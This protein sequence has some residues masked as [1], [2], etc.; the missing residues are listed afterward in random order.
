VFS[1]SDALLLRPVRLPE[2]ERLV[3]VYA[4]EPALGE[5]S[6]VVAG[7][8][9]LDWRA[10]A[11]SFQALAAY[12]RL[13][14]NL[15]GG[16]FP[17]RIS[18]VSV[19]PEFFDVLDVPAALGRT[20]RSGEPVGS[21][22]AVLASSFWQARFGADPDIIGR[23]VILNGEAHAI[24]GVMPPEFD[25]PP[26]A[27]IFVT[28]PHRVPLQPRDLTDM[29][30][31][32][33]AQY[34]SVVGRL[35]DGVSIA[36]A[37]AEMDGLAAQLALEFPDTQTDEGVSVV[38]LR[39]ALV[40]EVKPTLLL[41]L[42]AVG[43]VMLISCANVANLLTVRVSQ[44]GRELAVRLGLGASAARIRRQLL[45]ESV[46]LSLFG[47]LAGFA[48]AVGGTWGLV[49][50]APEGIP[51]L[52]EV[53]VDARVFGFST[54]LA[55]V[56]GVLFGLAPL[57]G[58][59][60]RGSGLSPWLRGS[61]ATEKYRSRLRDIVVV[62]EVALSLVLL[63]GAGLMVRTFQQLQDTDPGFDPGHT[64]VAH[65]SL[66][67][68]EYAEEGAIAA[69]YDDV[70]ARLRAIPE[71]ESAATVL[72]L[73]MHWAMRGTFT[74]AIEG[75]PQDAVDFPSAG[76]QV[77]SPDYFRTLRIPLLRG[78][79][80]D[81]SDRIET[82]TVA[83]INQALADRYWP[84]EDPVGKRLTFWGDPDDPETEW[85]TVIGV[86]ADV[87]TGGLDSSPEPEV[88]LAHSQ[89]ALNHTTFVVRTSG[90]P[91]SVASAVRN[92]VK[93]ADPALPLYGLL[94]MDEVVANAIAPR[95]YRMLLLS[96]FALVALAM[97]GAGL[98]GVLSFSVA[99]RGREIGIRKALGAPPEGVVLQV[100]RQGYAR[101]LI[102]L[103]LGILVSLT[104]SQ[105]I[106]TQIYGV[107]A[108]DVR[109]YVMAV[110]LLAA[111][112]LAASVVPAVHAARVDPLKAIAAE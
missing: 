31:N 99:Q 40:G 37:Q 3:Q 102:G 35:A 19:V 93:Q 33:G 81:G 27:S 13:S 61:L 54:I 73:P 80:I 16:E 21:R 2:P 74:F 112:A 32:R 64:L 36:A 58:V 84:G 8:T 95:R 90:D 9:Y 91:H 94:T 103:F 50:M 43:L 42:G 69:L 38:R 26:D 7:A 41:L 88:F 5:F 12:R 34:L 57:L 52:G 101:V 96:V 59:S 30:D 98:Y 104:L 86:V 11:Q 62:A 92:A 105:A 1:V 111:V 89:N 85:A 17:Q 28:S 79:S 76:Y 44:R 14:F 109:T 67:T 68:A 10:E 108:T 65:V 87:T 46:L 75:R 110:G 106:A 72:T 71:V 78:R 20:P 100:V 48:L 15:V 82:T 29:S 83:V 22:L 45:T 24:V 70:L 25:F 77:V 53:E 97:G 63:V 60:D 4:T 18:G 66:P 39:D 23:T 47:G 56:T 51:R 107:S 49:A 55:L 6:N